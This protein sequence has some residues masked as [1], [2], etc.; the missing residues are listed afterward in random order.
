M[1]DRPL[2]RAGHGML[3][4]K[5][6]PPHLG[7]V[8]LGEFA[9]HFVDRLTIVVGTLPTEP[10]PGT[11]R[12][13]WMK[14][15]FPT[16]KVVHLDE[17]LPQEPSEHPD[18]WNIWRTALQ[19]ILP[20]SPDYVFA[21]ENYGHRLAAELGAAFIP[22]DPGRT[23]RPVSGT[24]IRQNPHAH[25]EL[26]PPCVRPYFLT[27]V[28]IFGPESTGKS[29]LTADLAAAFGTLHVPEYARTFLETHGR[30]PTESDLL[31]IAHGQVASENALAPHANRYLFC[32]TDPLLTTIWSRFLFDRCDP[33]LEELATGHHYDLHVLTGTDVAY[34]DDKIRYLPERREE[35]H[36]VCREALESTGRR[37]IAVSGSRDERVE[38]V[39]AALAQL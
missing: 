14:E 22:V 2:K 30:E 36:R 21:S 6:L 10:I 15:L 38:Q 7:H 4:G 27:R 35:F 31:S 26:I 20:E 12:F 9:R 23:I 24:A 37:F 34:E 3:L 32:D 11:L 17:V 5:F 29:T 1:P 28:C 8:Y 39:S 19:R 33:A 18:F 13:E 25:W 16:A